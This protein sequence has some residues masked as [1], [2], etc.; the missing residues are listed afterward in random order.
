[1]VLIASFLTLLVLIISARFFANFYVDFLWH[2]SLGRTDVFWGTLR[3]KL[4]MLLIFGVAFIA[5]AVLNLM[6]A[7]RLAP[8]EFSAN[9]HPVVERFHEI[10]GRRMR[11]V[12]IGVA[13]L[14]GLLFAAPAVGQ[15]QDWLMF[16]NAKGF[17]IND[18]QF[19]ND[20][21]FYLFRLPFM[22]FVIDWLFAA[23]VI[24]IA[25]V[26]ATHVLNGGI[27]LQPPRPKVRRATKAHIAVLL[28]VLALVKAADYWVLRYELTAERRGLVRGATYSVAN[29]QLPAVVLLVMIAVLAAALFLVTLRTN[30]WRWPA[31]VC[32]LWAVV[33]LLGGV[34]YPAAVQKLLVEGDQENREALYIERNV[35]A[36]R[37]ALGI[38]NVEVQE[39][40]Y[41]T[42]A[43]EQIEADPDPLRNVRLL[44][45]TVM[46][47]RFQVDRGAQSGLRINDLD[48]DRYEVDGEMRQVV[49]GP[50]ELNVD[51]LA[52]PT[53]QGKHLI[54]THGCGLVFA[55]AGKVESDLS[56]S[57][58]DAPALERP[59]LYFSPN[60]SGFGIVGTSANENTCRDEE[61]AG[62][63]YEGAGGVRL[64]SVWRRAAFALH[65]LDYNLIGSRAVNEDSRILTIRS[66][67]ERVSKLAPFLRFDGD[68]YPVV[69]EGRVRW[70]VDGYTTSDR[71]PYGQSADTNQVRRNSGLTEPFNYVRN[72]VKAVVD[73]YDGTVTFYIVDDADP[74][75]RV[76]R[77]AFPDL[78]T[79][80]SEMP[81]D[82]VDH[83][84]Y[85]EDIFRVQTAA[86]SRYKLSPENFFA[87]SDR[88]AVAQ[89]PP[90]EQSDR[91]EAN[92]T[93]TSSTTATASGAAATFSPDD[94][95]ERFEPYY[96]L[97][98][99]TPDSD[100]SFQLYRPFTQF[101]VNNN[102]PSLQA[103]MTAGNDPGDYGKLTA[104][105]ISDTTLPPG[106]ITA[107]ATIA[108][109][110]VIS[111][112]I[113]Q[114]SSRGSFVEFGTMQM[115][116]LGEGV[117]WVQPMYVTAQGSNQPG[118]RYM[119]V[120]YNGRAAL[121]ASLEEAIGNRFAGADIDLGTQVDG[122]G[123]D[124]GD[125]G[126]PSTPPA[127]DQTAAE[128]LAQA[129]TLFA[130]ADAALAQ[131]DLAT[132]GA[133]VDE[134]RALVTRALELLNA[135]GG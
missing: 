1:V 86:Y 33:A 39:V 123:S 110:S 10:F 84:R 133:K 50:R 78:F 102:L 100:Q 94:S 49:I 15:W 92:N 51:G 41:G 113:T 104:Y 85:P 76:W 35:N 2:Q 32:A 26:I 97:F 53:W 4:W 106:P 132:Y 59:E 117:M 80:M 90:V 135:E 71:Y 89:A 9:T 54:S 6:I 8:L 60:V 7:D 64:S 5:P 70:V 122:G 127:A 68:P 46:L 28:A 62:D 109:D 20:V 73:G 115:V 55:D 21:G 13:V 87:Q 129:D 48:V 98:R 27:Q 83:L 57:Y 36:T 47:P 116:A 77:S 107:A 31:T 105:R 67:G 81:A 63:R 69:S 126:D 38:D 131:S 42:L 91:I 52:N 114:L 17:G 103:F 112:E 3:A 23:L 56:P 43:G 40:S 121:G 25:M 108:T 79:P 18:A 19:G 45:P 101:S 61:A 34:I 14:F 37:H 124:D 29:A 99:P 134:A 111:R 95:G 72:S 66:V 118:F 93:V 75:L 120:S 44:D 24:I 74:A 58:F 11:L 82:L 22:T 12:R 96:S 30:S 128:L 65:F 130:E 88:W 119:L 16:R 125:G